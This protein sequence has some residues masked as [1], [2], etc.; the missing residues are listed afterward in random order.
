ML[1]QGPGEGAGM[2]GTAAAGSGVM[3]RLHSS[4]GD[5]RG[6][7]ARVDGSSGEGWRGYGAWQIITIIT[8]LR[9]DEN[10]KNAC[11]V[12]QSYRQSIYTASPHY[13]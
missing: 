4:G 1:L 8:F 12:I 13:P 10:S 2:C 3:V 7:K 9:V 6:V 5:E 11:H